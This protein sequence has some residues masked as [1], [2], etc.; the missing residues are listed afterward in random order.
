MPK[1]KK[2]RIITDSLQAIKALINRT[3]V[4]YLA[5]A[6]AHDEMRKGRLEEVLTRWVPGHSGRFYN[7]I[8][9]D[10]SDVWQLTRYNILAEWNAASKITSLD[11]DK[12]AV[13]L[14]NCSY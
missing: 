5:A 10:F 11:K 9:D 14:I 6:R 7:I 1:L 3:S 12:L 4:N 8:E 13:W 2:I